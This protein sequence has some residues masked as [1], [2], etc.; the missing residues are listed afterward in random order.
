MTTYVDVHTL[1]PEERLNEIQ[2]ILV[3]AENAIVSGDTPTINKVT[4]VEM[5]RIYALACGRDNGATAAWALLE[6][7]PEPSQA[8]FEL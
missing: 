4:Q 7:V 1:T 2:D 5:A 8:G 6:R 3:D